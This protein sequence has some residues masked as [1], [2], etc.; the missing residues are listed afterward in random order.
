[1]QSVLDQA[2][3]PSG[4]VD[5]R[6]EASIFRKPV[7]ANSRDGQ[8]HPARIAPAACSKRR[9]VLGMT[10]DTARSAGEPVIVFMFDLL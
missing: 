8:K 6:E 10:A 5:A 4:V 1:M 2:A 3:E 7:I 9:R